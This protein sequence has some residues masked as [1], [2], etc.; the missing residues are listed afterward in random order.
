MSDA[1]P[2]AI[3]PSAANRAASDYVDSVVGDELF[4]TRTAAIA[5]SRATDPDVKAY[6]R[7]MAR[8]YAASRADMTQAI[9]ASAQDIAP[10]VVMSDH[11]QSMLD[12]LGQGSGPNFDKTYIDQQIEAQEETLGLT[13]AYAEGGAAPSIKAAA[14]RL[15]PQIQAH[16]DQARAIEDALNKKL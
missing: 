16:L 7:L 10:P 12:E 6:A 15:A 9:A 4:E 8:D 14:G 5:A 11:L 1:H 3:M 2:A 13:S